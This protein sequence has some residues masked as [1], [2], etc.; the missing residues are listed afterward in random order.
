MLDVLAKVVLSD[1]AHLGEY[2]GTDF[3][4]EELLVC[5]S[6]CWLAA[7]VNHLEGP[8]LHVLLHRGVGELAAD[9]P[10]GII[11]GVLGIR[12]RLILGSIANQPLVVTG[13]CN[14]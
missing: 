5:D 1:L 13:P 7:L 4:R 9:Q 10:L 6:D 3:L 11:D 14:I 2:H 8:V 12:S